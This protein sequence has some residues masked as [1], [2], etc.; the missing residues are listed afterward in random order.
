MKS[1]VRCENN[2]FLGRYVGVKVEAITCTCKL[3]LCNPKSPTKLKR[4]RQ[5]SLCRYCKWACLVA[6]KCNNNNHHHHHN[7]KGKWGVKMVC[8]W[9]HPLEGSVTGNTI[10]RPACL[11][12]H[13]ENC[14]TCSKRTVP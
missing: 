4:H 11:Q 2:R 13:G 8:G 9:S 1:C 3:L 14:V 10:R 12:T 5:A 6:Q 7:N